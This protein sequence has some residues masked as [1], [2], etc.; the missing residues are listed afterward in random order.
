[1]VLVLV[2]LLV[3]SPERIEDVAFSH[4]GRGWYFWGW[5][6]CRLCGRGWYFCRLCPLLGSTVAIICR[7]MSI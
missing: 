2:L 4:R 6:F 3:V 1:V 5:Y 7:C